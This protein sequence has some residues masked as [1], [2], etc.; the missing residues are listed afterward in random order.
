MMEG[1][2]SGEGE[3]WSYV[4][5]AGVPTLVLREPGKQWD[6]GMERRTPQAGCQGAIS[7]TGDLGPSQA[8]VLPPSRS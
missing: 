6:R 1:C 4:V 8:T 3:G 2:S 7:A 5:G